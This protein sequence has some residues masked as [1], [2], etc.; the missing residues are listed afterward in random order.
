MSDFQ[1]QVGVSEQLVREKQA[2]KRDAC[3]AQL[4]SRGLTPLH[5]RLEANI[6]LNVSALGCEVVVDGI[7]RFD[8]GRLSVPPIIIPRDH[9][10]QLAMV[11][12]VVLMMTPPHAME[13]RARPTL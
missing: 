2:L 5:S 3:A 12:L 4:R 7:A 11:R 8:L 10:D 1:W 9:F 13:V 6:M